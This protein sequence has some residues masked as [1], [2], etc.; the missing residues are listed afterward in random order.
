MWSHAFTRELL[1]AKTMKTVSMTRASY[2]HSISRDEWVTSPP[3]IFLVFWAR[4]ASEENTSVAIRGPAFG[5]LESANSK[6]RSS[7]VFIADGMSNSA[8]W[9][10][11]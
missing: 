1:I 9:C 2:G 11:P 3:D 8:K 6:N 7:N 4:V 10:L 5:D